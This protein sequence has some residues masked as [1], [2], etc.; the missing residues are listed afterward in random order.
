MCYGI[1]PDGAVIGARYA[2]GAFTPIA[3]AAPTDDTADNDVNDS[4]TYGW[5]AGV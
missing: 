5:I 1:G 2:D 3:A 4:N